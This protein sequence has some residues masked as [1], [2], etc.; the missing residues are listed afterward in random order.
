[1]YNL[2]ARRYAFLLF[3]I[4]SRHLGTDVPFRNLF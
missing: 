1:M 4:T 3:R 2:A